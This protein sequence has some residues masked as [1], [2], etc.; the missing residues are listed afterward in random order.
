[1]RTAKIELNGQD[2]LLCFSTGV[3]EAACERYGSLDDYFAALDTGSQLSRLQTVI[4]SLAVMM[5]A[6]AKYAALQGMENPAPLTE[7]DIRDLTDV[8]ELMGLQD[9]VR[10]TITSGSE[11]EVE[12][13]PPK[14]VPATPGPEIGDP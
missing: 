8:T 6:G 11:R 10:E 14:N 5:D 1:M 3:V 7:K 9:K 2:H 12:A 13:E 4:W